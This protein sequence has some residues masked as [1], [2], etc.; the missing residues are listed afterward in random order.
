MTRAHSFATW[1]NVGYPVAGGIAWLAGAPWP[2]ALWFGVL[3]VASFG[4]HWWEGQ[5]VWRFRWTD[6][7]VEEYTNQQDISWDIRQEMDGNF[8]HREHHVVEGGM[9]PGAASQGARRWA[10][11]DVWAMFGLLLAVTLA[12]VAPPWWVSLGASGGAAYGIRYHLIRFMGERTQWWTVGLAAAALLATATVSL[13]AAGIGG[14]LLL[15]GT[16]L[17]QGG[18]RW[19][20][21]WSHAAWHLFAAAGTAVLAGGV[22]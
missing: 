6:G 5:F 20:W 4:F 15:V 12:P 9:I 2:V 7:T 19:D 17:R 3:G 16:A 11:A 18:E 21:W 13:P 1:T 10:R 22:G 8:G 14:A